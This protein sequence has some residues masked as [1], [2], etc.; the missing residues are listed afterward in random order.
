[1]G[2]RITSDARLVGTPGYIAPEQAEGVVGHATADVYSV[3]VVL[4]EA[5]VGKPPFSGRSWFEVL[6]LHATAPRPELPDPAS[7]GLKAAVARAIQ[8]APADRFQS[9]AEL[10]DALV[11]TPEGGGK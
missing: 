6:H 4:F 9:M 8:A 1:M 7:P 11:Q 10:E 3:G 5:I 2:I